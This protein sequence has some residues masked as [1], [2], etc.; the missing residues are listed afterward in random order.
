MRPKDAIDEVSMT[1]DGDEGS[2]IS[3]PNFGILD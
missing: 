2:R 1:K 3:S